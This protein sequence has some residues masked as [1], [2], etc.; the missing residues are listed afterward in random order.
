[1][2]SD[3][4]NQALYERAMQIMPGGHSNLRI[5]LGVKP[6]FIYTSGVGNGH[7]C[8]REAHSVCF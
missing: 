6:L 5:P 8:N 1:M 2:G 7:I 4:K 3:V